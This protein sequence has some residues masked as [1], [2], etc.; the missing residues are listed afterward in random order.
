MK[1]IQDDNENSLAIYDYYKNNNIK[2]VTVGNGLKSDY[3]YDG[4]GNVQ[5]LVTISSKWWSFSR[6]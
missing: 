3:T 4:D 6:L 2:S 5:S 1:L